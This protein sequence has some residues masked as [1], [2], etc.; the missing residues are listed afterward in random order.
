[1]LCLFSFI[2]V[3][4]IFTRK[5]LLFIENIDPSGNCVNSNCKSFHNFYIPVAVSL[6]QILKRDVLAY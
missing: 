1:V 5:D 6:A 2:I 3:L 4:L